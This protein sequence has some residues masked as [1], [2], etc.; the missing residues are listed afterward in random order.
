MASPSGAGGKEVARKLRKVRSDTLNPEKLAAAAVVR[1]G[2]TAKRLAAEAAA[3]EK[4]TS[5][6]TGK[7]NWAALEASVEARQAA[8]MAVQEAAGDPQAPQRPS[9]TAVAAV[10][11]AAADAGMPFPIG[12]GGDGNEGEEDVVAR[13]MRAAIHRTLAMHQV[14]A[15]KRG[16][17]EAVQ[18]G[19]AQGGGQQPPVLR[20]KKAAAPADE[21]SEIMPADEDTPPLAPP[22]VLAAQ[23]VAAQVAA[24]N[25]AAN[26]RAK[27]ANLA[28]AMRTADE[29]TAAEAAAHAKAQALLLA[30]EAAHAQA[31]ALGA[32][33]SDDKVRGAIK[34]TKKDAVAS[35]IAGTR[36]ITQ[37]QL[38]MRFG[39]PL[40]EAAKEL[41][42]APGSTPRRATPSVRSA[43][44]SEIM[45]A[46]PTPVA[47]A[48]NSAQAVS[49]Y[50]RRHPFG[51]ADAGEIVAS[52]ASPPAAAPVEDVADPQVEAAVRA[53]ARRAAR[54]RAVWDVEHAA[55][56]RLKRNPFNSMSCAELRAVA[57]SRVR[58]R[59][60]VA[61]SIAATT[62]MLPAAKARLYGVVASASTYVRRTAVALSA[63]Q[64]R[65]QAEEAAA[66]RIQTRVRGILA[67]RAAHALR[68]RSK[69]EHALEVMPVVP[70]ALTARSMESCLQELQAAL[71]ATSSRNAAATAPP[72]KQPASGVGPRA[73]SGGPGAT[74]EEL[75]RIYEDEGEA[76]ALAFAARE[77]LRWT[78]LLLEPPPPAEVAPAPAAEAGAT[79]PDGGNS[80]SDDDAGAVAKAAA[81]FAARN[82][83]GG[84]KTAPGAPSVSVVAPNSALSAEVN[85]FFK[86]SARAVATAVTSPSKGKGAR[87]TVVLLSPRARRV[88]GG[89]ASGSDEDDDSDEERV[90]AARA[91]LAA[92]NQPAGAQHKKYTGPLMTRDRAT[93]V[94]QA[95]MRGL[96]ARRWA[97]V[98]RCRLD[99]RAAVA[100]AKEMPEEA[101]PEVI[102]CMLD[103][104][105]AY[106]RA[107]DPHNAEQAYSVALESIEREYGQGDPRCRKPAEI[108]ARIFADRGDVGM[109]QEVLHRALGDTSAPVPA[110]AEEAA[111]YEEYNNSGPLKMVF[112][113]GAWMNTAVD[114]DELVD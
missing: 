68:A 33:H 54:D 96:V 16:G 79:T 44:D 82:K 29:K 47:A 72:P 19:D 61:R 26:A 87:K 48:G 25:A 63:V 9:L 31:R 30:A 3:G 94:I 8:Q 106:L 49:E 74:A 52:P 2:F 65:Q 111:E 11:K 17:G 75:L 78:Q 114:G 85:G 88:A 103:L 58:R 97:E 59:A 34:M 50:E 101:H 56:E 6:G 55:Q 35:N 84:R 67:R 12:T 46:E 43:G 23:A 51:Q 90:L 110:S 57:A 41:T 76:A 42:K 99:L 113:L 36:A 105:E 22:H 15:Q 20:A 38:E 81:F 60:A 40:E 93:V 92:K 112:Q 104:G 108:L 10:A 64:R 107:W 27:A 77:T 100:E 83:A 86:P 13:A 53:R 21:F 102:Q 70:S 5:G 32:T 37:L 98:Q 18:A 45:P 39:M 7:L 69:L 28:V 24:D 71:V 4:G 1:A 66:V 62:P 73:H 95:H 14:A 80:D 109:A 89:A 91:K